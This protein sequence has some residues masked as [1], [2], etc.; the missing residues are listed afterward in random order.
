MPFTYFL[1]LVATSALL[2]LIVS[3]RLSFV[4]GTRWGLSYKNKPGIPYLGIFQVFSALGTAVICAL[5]TGAAMT[6]GGWSFGLVAALCTI[7]AVSIVWIF[8]VGAN[9][10]TTR[11]LSRLLASVDKIKEEK[12]KGDNVQDTVTAVT[13]SA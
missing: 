7:P 13:T 1:A 11:V 3:T 5:G 4:M 12:A 8:I 9:Q 10:V 2:G 6:F